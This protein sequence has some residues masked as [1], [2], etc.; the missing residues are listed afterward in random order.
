MLN[1]RAPVLRDVADDHM[2]VNTA[3]HPDLT[4]RNLAIIVPKALGATL[5]S[6]VVI[7]QLSRDHPDRIIRCIAS[8]T[9]LLQGSPYIY[10][11]L[12]RDD[13]SVF[14]RA[15]R[16]NDVIDL[17]GTLTYQP[18]RRPEPVHLID[19]LCCRARVANDGNGPDC[20]LTLEEIN[21]AERLIS[22]KRG[23]TRKKVIAIATQ[24]STP[25]KEWPQAK[26][27]A[28]IQ[29]IG[30][31][32]CWL[33][34]GDARERTLPG[35]EY[36]SLTPRQSIALTRCVDGIVTGDTFLLHAAATQRLAS[37]GVVTLLGSSHP[38]CVSYAAFHNV[39]IK[40]YD[41]QPCGRPYSPF[42]VALLPDGSIE[43]WKNG[44]A[45]LWECEHV[46]C[47]DLISVEAVLD[48]VRYSIM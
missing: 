8:F 26:W 18:N 25:N 21:A 15:I 38:D 5:L 44:K 39:Y 37:A 45:K 36:L 19:L 14:E 22:H 40:E 10:E 43:R 17:S 7:R 2:A 41:C 33:H 30:P 23:G 46:A 24:T 34:L 13:P 1:V 47:M 32:V 6:T 27:R 35:V 3:L 31:L 12:H 48:A 16:D 9:D 20:F 28:L 11:T 29:R 42:D 4:F